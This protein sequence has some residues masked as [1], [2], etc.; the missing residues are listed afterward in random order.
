MIARRWLL[1]GLAALLLAGCARPQPVALADAEHRLDDYG[2]SLRL[3]PDW[4]LH[5]R[6]GGLR[7]EARP[8]ANGQPVPGVYF[9]VD[10]DA[11]R[12]PADGLKAPQPTLDSYVARSEQLASHDAYRYRL[13]DQGR[14]LLDGLPAVW[15]ERAYASYTMQRR[16]YAAMTVRGQYG[17]VLVGSAFEANYRRW[18]PTFEAIA[19]SLRWLPA[20]ESG[21]QSRI[22]AP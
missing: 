13:A 17:Y 1:A 20:G 3:P 6:E 7:W 19:A 2:L 22:I 4:Q 16:S 14:L 8:L 9:I 18:A 5:E 15:H 21:G 12:E 11:A 10:R